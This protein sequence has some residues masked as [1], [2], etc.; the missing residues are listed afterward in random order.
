MSSRC[1]TYLRDEINHLKTAKDL[2]SAELNAARSEIRKLRMSQERLL[3]REV[4]RNILGYEVQDEVIAALKGEFGQQYSTAEA[5][6]ML[7]KHGFDPSDP[8]RGK[9]VRMVEYSNQFATPI[10]YFCCL[11]NIQMCDWLIENTAAGEDIRKVDKDGWTPMYWACHSGHLSS[12]QWLFKMGAA[13]D[14]SKVNSD[15][16]TPMGE[17]CWSGHLSICKWLYEVGASEDIRKVNNYGRTPMFV[18]CER[19]HLHICKWLFE[20]GATTDIRSVNIAGETSMFWACG[21]GHLDVCKWLFDVGAAE[22]ICKPNKAGRTPMFMASLNGH[23]SVC[24]WLACAGALNDNIS[25]N[26]EQPMVERSIS[27]WAHEALFE[28]AKA[29]VAATKS[30]RN[31]I[32]MGT[33]TLV[34]DDQAPKRRLPIDIRRSNSSLETLSGKPGVLE[35]VA[36]FVG[37]IL[38][39]RELRNVR[40]LGEHLN[41]ITSSTERALHP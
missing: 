26:I 17:A 18:A 12:C 13:E 1:E 40:Q 36:D 20:V 35:S 5:N 31:T 27:V 38:R 23:L 14:I 8:R 3:S 28:W 41:N 7:C 32:L 34:V 39:G 30:F 11:G 33:L 15:G 4:W 19:G 22:D 29:V 10:A 9:R 2:A 16:Y 21:N 24:Q 37:N 25:G 6:N